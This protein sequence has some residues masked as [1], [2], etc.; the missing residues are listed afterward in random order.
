MSS[1]ATAPEAT[2][3]GPRMTPARAAVIGALLTA[4]GSMSMALYTP[5]MPTLVGAFGT[6]MAMVKTTL[7]AYFAGFAIAQLVCG[8]LSDAFGRRPIAFLFLALY[9]LGGV[10]ALFAPTVEILV[11]ARLVQGVG[12]AVGISVSR[13]VVRDLFTGQESARVLNA[14]GIVLS[15]GPAVAPTLGGVV[16][17][18]AGWRAIFVV[19]VVLAIVAVLVV[20][21][22]MPETNHAPDRD[23]ARPRRVVS[24]YADLAVDPRFLR[25]ALTLG[26]SVGSIYALGTLLPFVL[27]GRVGLDPTLFGLGMLA[28]TGSYFLGGLA[29]RRL[30]NTIGAERLVLPGLVAAAVGACGTLLLEHVVEPSW[31][32]VMA[33]I[34]VYAFSVAMVIPALTTAVLAPF[35]VVAG[36]ASSLLGFVQMGSGF[37]GGLLGA[38]FADPVI[39]LQVVFPVMQAAAL[40]TFVLVPRR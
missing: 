2:P 7:T 1:P 15:I 24:T 9:G 34:A 22:Y 16:L 33:P 10:A 38:L 25:P 13:A 30:M 12:A 26:V 5:A 37:V 21:L 28:Q 20:H 19:M 40:A 4:L 18:I 29:A 23:L 36:S 8:P 17:T 31:A 3:P 35:P 14:I 6:T 11:A 39:A 32:T 27:I